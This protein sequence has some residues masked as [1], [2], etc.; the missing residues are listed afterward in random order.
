MPRRDNLAHH[1]SWGRKG[2][3]PWS[4]QRSRDQLPGSAPYLSLV[5]I[6]KPGFSATVHILEGQGLL[7]PQVIS[8]P[9]TVR[10]SFPN[11]LSQKGTLGNDS[12]GLPMSW[13]SVPRRP[14][15]SLG[16]SDGRSAL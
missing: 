14:L 11:S 2:A 1:K 10:L 7:V 8:V 9:G 13:F 6:T 5:S 12:E 15:E 3:V 4:I 16:P